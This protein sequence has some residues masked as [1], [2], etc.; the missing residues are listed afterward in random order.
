MSESKA[1]VK[2]EGASPISNRNLA[3]RLT[4]ESRQWEGPY[5]PGAPQWTTRVFLGLMENWAAESAA[6]KVLDDSLDVA[7]HLRNV[8]H[9]ENTNLR[10]RE[11][12]REVAMTFK[13]L[14]RLMW[15]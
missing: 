13:T 10:V 12:R 5:L 8:T 6:G 11:V 3:D 1:L 15:T 14:R 4:Y 9:F 2:S 7:P